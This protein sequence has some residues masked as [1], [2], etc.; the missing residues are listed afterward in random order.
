V[1]S[2]LQQKLHRRFRGALIEMSFAAL[3]EGVLRALKST[4]PN[5]KQRKQHQVD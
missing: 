1:K 2:Y 5:A 3:E 4:G